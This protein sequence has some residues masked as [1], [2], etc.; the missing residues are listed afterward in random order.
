MTIKVYVQGEGAVLKVSPNAQILQGPA[1][2]ARPHPVLTAIVVEG[3]PEAAEKAG[4]QGV[5]VV[6]AKLKKV[7]DAP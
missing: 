1:P 2:F 4:K 3:T 7:G 6:K 5:V